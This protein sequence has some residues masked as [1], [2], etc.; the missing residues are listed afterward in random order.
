M[1]GVQAGRQK[2]FDSE[3]IFFLADEV[4]VLLGLLAPELSG[5][6]SQEKQMAT[7]LFLT[8]MRSSC[9]GEIFNTTRVRRMGSVAATRISSSLFLASSSAFSGCSS[10]PH[11]SMSHDRWNL[12]A[13]LVVLNPLRLVKPLLLLPQPLAFHPFPFSLR[14]L[15]PSAIT[16]NNH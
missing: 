16:I 15:H 4:D 11:I 12:L 6:T 9:S 10:C 2:Y 14:L 8:L 13:P 7:F 1:A 3:L 5:H